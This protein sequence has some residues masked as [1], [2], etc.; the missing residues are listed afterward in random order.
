MKQV[1]SLR[2]SAGKIAFILQVGYFR[3]SQRFFGNGFYK[4]DIAFVT[5]RL[6][7][8]IPNSLEIPKQT[9]AR[10]RTIIAEF[11]G[12]R[13]LT[14]NDKEQLIAGI[15]DLVKHFHCPAEVFRHT[16]KK[17]NSRKFVLPGYDFLA[18]MISRE[19]FQRKLSLSRIIKKITLIRAKTT[20]GFSP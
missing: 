7:L 12:F 1:K 16:I 3:S 6:D 11:Y 5:G 18:T 15:A 13:T 17:L 9:L 4:S 2:T 14:K 20:L 19:I 10:H 8:P